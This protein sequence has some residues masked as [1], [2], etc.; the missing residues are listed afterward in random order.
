MFQFD[1]VILLTT[2]M[3]QDNL[4]DLIVFGLL[5]LWLLVDFLGEG[6]VE[7]ALLHAL[8]EVIDEFFDAGCVLGVSVP[9]VISQ[10]KWGLL[11]ETP[12]TCELL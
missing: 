10:E 9:G 7:H 12:L 6:S 4:R 1:E 2:A 8:V 3:P 11:L 5:A